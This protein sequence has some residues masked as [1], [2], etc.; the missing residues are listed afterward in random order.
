MFAKLP[1]ALASN[2]ALE[3]HARFCDLVLAAAIAGGPTWRIAIQN[4]KVT[5]QESDAGDATVRLEA[6]AAA[7]RKFASAEPPPGYQALIAMMTTGDFTVGGDHL[8]FFRHLRLIEALFQSIRPARPTPPPIAPDDVVIENVTGRYMRLA[9]EGRPH[10][11]YFEEAGAGIPLLCLHTAGSDGRQFRAVLNDTAVTRRF[12]VIAFDLPYHGKSSPPPGFQ[13]EIYTL[14]TDRYVN[15]VMA[16]K[17]ALRLDRPVVM[18]CSI[19]GRAVLHLALRHGDEFRAGIGLQS[20]LYAEP[21]NRYGSDMSQLHRPDV[22]GAEVGA[23]SVA[24][25]I[26]PQSPDT[27]RWETL[28]HYMQAGP[29]IFMGDLNYYFADGD[30][31]NGMARAIDTKKCPLYLLSG[32]YDVSAKPEMGADLARQVNAT[33]FEVMREMGHFPMSE[34]PERFRDYL[35]PILDMISAA[36]R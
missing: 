10:R 16:V 6:S 22:D 3:R 18:G 24:S 12:R 2:P 20:A 21:G 28:W 4:G 8:A 29:G 13:N 5:A 31:R 26:A 33:H 32:E 1:Q 36:V 23:A 30:M 19:G 11:V 34:N 15:T 17:R 7:W 14:T 35:L 9:I 27:E 25:L